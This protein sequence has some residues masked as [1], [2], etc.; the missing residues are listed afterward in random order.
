M[1][2]F[3]ASRADRADELL[4]LY[5]D[6]CLSETELEELS[7]LLVSSPELRKLAAEY[8]QLH[9]DLYDLLGNRQDKDA[10]PSQT[11]GS[12]SGPVLGL[13]GWPTA[14]DPIVSFIK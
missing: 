1:S 8:A 12:S 14:V 9:A 10:A 2:D 4:S 3:K 5:F 11:T 13:P 7:E 6:Q